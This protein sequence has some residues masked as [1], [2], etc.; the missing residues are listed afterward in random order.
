MAATTDDGAALALQLLD[1]AT[2]HGIFCAIAAHLPVATRGRC[3]CVCRA[4]RAALANSR[5]W[6]RLDLS[7]AATDALLCAAAARAGG[8]LRAL[9]VTDCPRVTRA[10]L[11]GVVRENAN[12]LRE[13]RIGATTIAADVEDGEETLTLQRVEALCRLA[14]QLQ[15][16]HTSLHCTSAEG[17]RLR[18][19]LHNEPPFGAVHVHHLAVAFPADEIEEAVWQ[20]TQLL[21]EAAWLEPGQP[22]AP[23]EL[24]TVPALAAHVAEH[25]SLTRLRV[26]CAPLR[27]LAALDLLVDAAL[28]RRLSALTLD[29]CRLSPASAPALARL[30]HG[31]ALTEL[32]VGN[33][34]KAWIDAP[35]AALLCDALRGNSTL[36]VLALRRLDFWHTPA[37]ATALL[38][39]LVGHPTLHT[40][41]LCEDVAGAALP[42]ADSAALAM[43]ALVAANAPALQ[44]LEIYAPACGDAEFGPLVDALPRNT[45]LRELHCACRI[46]EA[47]ARDRLLPAVRANASLRQ[48]IACSHYAHAGAAAWMREAE[49]L[50]AARSHAGA[51]VA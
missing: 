4:W 41:G 28:A 25:A 17:W 47:F 2:A 37:A 29:A 12:T 5:M 16:L 33:A 40:L 11:L 1:N 49:A 10:A 31:D 7:G 36:R 22:L 45:H 27:E 50:V 18:R 24:L 6:L 42:P 38:R 23:T 48:L 13:L 15:A 30:L 35:G 8:G 19:S 20:F 39:A 34:S 9:D 14:P 26:T 21:Q 3:A 46:S 32:V 44:R 43:A 51:D